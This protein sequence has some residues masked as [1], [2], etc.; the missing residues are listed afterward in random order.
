[1]SISTIKIYLNRAL[2]NLDSPYRVDEVEPD[3]LQAEQRLPNVSPEDAAPLVAQIADIRAKLENVVSPADARQVK[4]AEGKIRQARDFIE[5]NHGNLNQSA[6]DHVEEL[7]Q[8]AIQFLDQITDL[9]KANKL[10]AP[11]L[12]EIGTIRTQ[13]GSNRVPAPVYYPPPPFPPPPKPAPSQNFSRAKNKVF[14]AK[15]YFNTPGRIE[16]TEPELAQA[17]QLLEGDA[18]QEADALRAEIAALRDN[19]ADIVMPAEEAYIRSAQRDVQGVRDYIDRQRE[20]LDKADTKQELDRQLQKIIEE[21][22]NRIKH[23][24]KAD[25]LKA[26]ILAE[27]ALIRS[28]LNVVPSP[29]PQTPQPLV[30][31]AWAQTWGQSLVQAQAVPQASP[32]IDLNALSYDDQDRLNRARRGI[33]QARNNIESGRTEGVENLFFDA[34]NIL[35]PVSNAHKIHLVAEIEQLRRDLEATRLAESTRIITGDLDRKLQRVEMD[36][37]APDRLQYSVISFKQRFEQ[38]DVRRILTPNT[39]R[40]YESRLANVLAAGNAQIKTMKL[41]RANPALQR[42]QDKLSTNP[43]TGI[44]QYEA[45]R[46]D[47]ELRSMKWQV[48]KE[49]NELPEDDP[50]RLRIYELLKDIDDKFAAYSNE[51]AKTG[52]HDAV[53]RE[54]QMVRDEVQ[55][56]EQESHS[57]NTQVLEDPEPSMSRTRLAIH[58]AYYYLHKDTSAQRTRNENPGDSVIAAVDREAEQVLEAAG[59]KLSSAYYQII[60]AAEKIETPVGD[61]WLQDKPGYL[62]TNAQTTF[63]N[64]KFCEPVIDR[65]RALDQRW[66]DELEAVHLGRG[67]L[68]EKLSSEAIQK[69]PSIVAAIPSIVSYFD[70]SSAKPGDAV[71]FNGVY[72]RAGWDFDGNQYGFSMRYNGVPLGGIYEPYINKALDYAAYQLKLTIDDHKEWDLV[73]IVLGPGSINQRTKKTIRIGMHTEEVE[74]WL[75]EGCLRL[76]IIALRAGP[77]VV[78]P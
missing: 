11:I 10:K 2:E 60:E 43:F 34:T 70:P 47:S 62:I 17:E 73:G 18:S 75:P 42:L 61:R 3:L 24:R 63:E 33:A 8:G 37:E 41:N 29:Y 52:I 30:G 48:E 50:D 72:N 74:E 7:F 51:W 58:R 40:D 55:G 22:L 65:I 46:V 20:F 53:K 28:Q 14:W 68:G 54:W 12:A 38:D 45:N 27:I 23:P 44:Q 77:V 31:P 1:M 9:R 16:Q 39:Y 49:I 64:T 4:A 35:A 15:E 32:R 5:T 25:Q 6:K 36:V 19:L 13:Y 69:W 67:K 78:G 71:H 21:G 26:P 56:W 76:R 57:S 59:T 66:K